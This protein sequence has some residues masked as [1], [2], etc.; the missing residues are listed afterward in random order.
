MTTQKNTIAII[1]GHF[2]PALAAVEGAREEDLDILFFG[3]KHAFSQQT[4]TSLE[5]RTIHDIPRVTWYDIESGRS[6][7]G[8]P[9]GILSSAF[10]TLKAT[11][12]AATILAGKR[13]KCILGFG[14]Y[15]SVPVCIAGWLLRIPIVIHE[16]TVVP[17]RANLLLQFFASKILVTFPQTAR[18]FSKNKV[19]VSGIPMTETQAKQPTWFKNSNNPML[20]IMGGSAGSH[21]INIRI[22]ELV[23]RLS[24]DFVVVH[25]TGDNHYEDFQRLQKIQSARYFPREFLS[26]SELRYLLEK[27]EIVVT[28]TGAN[29]FFLLTQ[30]RNPVVMIPL[31]WSIRNEQLEL[32][33]I[34]EDAHVGIA[35][36]QSEQ[37]TELYSIIR[38]VF[39]RK[40]E[41]KKNY[42]SLNSYR[43]LVVSGREI[44]KKALS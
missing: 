32:S 38:E 17:G 15:L 24:K 43:K 29:T 37:A 9:F 4:D 21:S 2:A 22:E 25:Q 26:S 33:K 13:P 19:T 7:S 41:F 39:L 20:L 34:L 30:T 16:Q 5:Y 12:R 14:S 28:R 11:V 18:S 31:P 6:T 42:D 40:E 8:S 27:A 10:S 23:N 3:R 35:Y 36:S 44:V 1:G